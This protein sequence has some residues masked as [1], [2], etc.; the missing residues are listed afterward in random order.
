M[1]EPNI[2]NSTK[3]CKIK[4][5][6]DV[7][8]GAHASIKRQDTGVMYLTSKNFKASGLD[9]SNV[10]F[11]TE[12]DYEK[13]FSPSTKA[14]KKLQT[15]DVL[16]GIIGSLGVPYVFKRDD[17]FGI[18]SSVAI[19]R[20]KKNLNSHYLYYFM[21]S[22]FFQQAI[23]ATKSGVAQG[24]L[25]LEMIRNL[26]FI[27]LD[28]PTQEK[29]AAILS[30]Y[31]DLIENNQKRIALL[32]KAAEEIYRE[33]FVRMRFPSWEK[34]KFEKGIPVGWELKKLGELANTQYGYTTSAT[35]EPIGPKFLR[36]TDIVPSTIT[37]D[38]VPFCAIDENLRDKYLLHE[39]DIVVART[40]ATV[41]Y[42]KRINKLHPASIFASYLVRL[43]PKKPVQN[44]FLGIAIESKGFKNFIRMFITGAAQPQ[45]NAK[46]MSSFPL[47]L[48]PENLLIQFNKL[49][50]PILDKKE[51]L[52]L[53]NSK[54]KISRDLLLSRLISGKLAVDEL[55]IHFPPSMKRN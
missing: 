5:F 8:D 19:L 46:I 24:F 17:H 32:E 29:I 2:L 27:I 30:A 53:T 20:P 12:A 47:L 31:D 38:E 25:S 15:G 37:W 22:N 52:N 43:K 23:H 10:D 7:G 49:V 50:E 48:P 36:I 35:D 41:G 14:I 21:T 13:Y 18:S 42:A 3:I 6:C 33:W 55:E 26:P 51:L 44:I 34:T 39:G 45:A 1:T 54:I 9:L 11:I 4:D 40:G 16:F 28:E